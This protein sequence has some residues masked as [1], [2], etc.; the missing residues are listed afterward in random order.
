MKGTRL[1]NKFSDKKF[2]WGQWAILGS[3]IAHPHNSGSAGI[4]FFNILPN[5][6]GLLVDENDINNFPK[7]NPFGAN[8]PVWAKKWHILIT[9]DPL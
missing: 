2:H 5:E 7:K 8:G 4:I 9:L 1:I 6:R 3:K